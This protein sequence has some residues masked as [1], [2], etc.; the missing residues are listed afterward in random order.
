[1]LAFSVVVN[2]LILKLCIV[3]RVQPSVD[4]FRVVL[5]LRAT[6]RSTTCRILFDLVCL[7][8]VHRNILS[9]QYS[10]HSCSVTYRY[11][12]LH[13]CGNSEKANA[14]TPASAAFSPDVHHRPGPYPHTLRKTTSQAY[15][16]AE[17]SQ[18][19]HSK[20][21][22]IRRTTQI[23]SQ[24]MVRSLLRN[25]GHDINGCNVEPRSDIERQKNS[26]AI[27][28]PQGQEEDEETKKRYVELDRAID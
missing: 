24:S 15:L 4:R 14:T 8:R 28:P 23:T 5:R 13:L 20:M 9:I 18:S 21:I 12:G 26:T 2:Y 1:M 19:R 7:V 17:C 6:Q 22:P 16:L 25:L 11:A 27:D 10:M 3:A